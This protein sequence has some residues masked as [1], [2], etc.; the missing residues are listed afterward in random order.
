MLDCDLRVCAFVSSGAL[1]RVR[2][3]MKERVMVDVRVRVQI[4]ETV[5]VR[6]MGAVIFTDSFERGIFM[7]KVM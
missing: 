3:K 6:K 5:R 2:V 7:F 4:T 1:V